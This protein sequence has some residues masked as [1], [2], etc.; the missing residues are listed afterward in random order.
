MTTALKYI[1]NSQ[2]DPLLGSLALFYQSS[3]LSFVCC[4]GLWYSRTAGEQERKKSVRFLQKRLWRQA[5]PGRCKAYESAPFCSASAVWWG[6]A[7]L[8]PVFISAFVDPGD[9][10]VCGCSVVTNK[11]EGGIV[12][13]RGWAALQSP[14]YS[15]LSPL[16]ELLSVTSSFFSSGRTIG[17]YFFLYVF[18]CSLQSSLFNYKFGLQEH[19][20]VG[21]LNL[22]VSSFHFGREFSQKF[23]GTS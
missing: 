5:S 13:T 9:L 4:S 18:F 8:S 15:N 6:G 2:L 19:F 22:K 14:E 21:I 12:V 1:Q 11:C 7:S 17:F 20:A 10:G 23:L 3:P 16:L